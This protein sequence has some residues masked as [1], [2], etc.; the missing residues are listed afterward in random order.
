MVFLNL[1]IGFGA[2]IVVSK[3]FNSF[4]ASGIILR[5]MAVAQIQA[6][7]MLVNTIKHFHKI[8][9]WHDKVAW[10]IDDAQKKLKESIE[11][12]GG[13]EVKLP[14]GQTT[15]IELAEED[16]KEVSENW[17]DSRVQ[18]LKVIWN[19]VEHEEQDWRNQS[20]L[21]VKTS[22]MPYQELCEWNTWNE[23]MEYLA[24][25]ELLLMKRMI[26]SVKSNK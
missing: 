24:E 18:E 2:G 12:S 21:L 20:A 10:S 25:Y 1:L 8:R 17:S 26:D 11:R 9:H 14:D 15:F 13:V 6:L 7:R 5:T 4:K 16:I 23:A 19:E 22:M 3:V